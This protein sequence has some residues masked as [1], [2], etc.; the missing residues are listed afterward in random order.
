[1]ISS[2]GADFSE[3]Q[4]EPGYFGTNYKLAPAKLSVWRQQDYLNRKIGYKDGIN[5]N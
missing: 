4:S 2:A 5:I 1:M 3:A